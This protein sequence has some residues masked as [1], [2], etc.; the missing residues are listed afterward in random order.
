MYACLH[1]LRPFG[2]LLVL[3]SLAIAGCHSDGTYQRAKGLSGQVDF[4][5]H[6]R[7]ILSDNC[8]A[9][10]GPD[11]S[12]REAK[13]RLDI[14]EAAYAELPES[15]GAFAIVPGKPSKSQ[16][17]VRI[18][19]GDE[20]EVMPPVESKLSLDEDEKEVLK[21]WIQQGAE[22]K[23]L[24]SLIPLSDEQ[25]S[26]KKHRSNRNEIDRLVQA[27]L[28][29]SGLTLADKASKETLIR[30]AAFDLTGLPPTLEDIDAFVADNQTD[31]FN[32][33]IDA[34]LSSPSYGERMAS[35]WMD[36]ARYADSDG[37]LDDKH[38][39]FSPWRDWVIRAFNDNLPYNEFVTW[40]LAGDL[41]V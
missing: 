30:R 28:K 16:L 39:D 21:R 8:Y 29:R 36:I 33:V 23:P 9:C 18:N 26:R 13:L 25:L 6:V 24:W 15:P 4:N 31:A 7:P 5:A 40:Q 19:E 3:F 14:A 20:D 41:F 10:H 27:R 12:N 17:L 32:R 1:Y 22:Y 37:Y 11:A 2:F 35:L 38:R 34:Y